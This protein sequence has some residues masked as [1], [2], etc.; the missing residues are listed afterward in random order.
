MQSWYDEMNEVKIGERERER[1][2]DD[3]NQDCE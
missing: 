1:E 3:A 2:L